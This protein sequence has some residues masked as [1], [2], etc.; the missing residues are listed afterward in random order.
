MEVCRAE[1]CFTCEKQKAVK[2]NDRKQEALYNS[3][4]RN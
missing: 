3:L 4:R 1:S 2:R